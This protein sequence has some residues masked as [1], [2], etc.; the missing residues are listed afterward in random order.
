MVIGLT[1]TIGSGKTLVANILKEEFNVRIVDTDSISKEVTKKGTEALR[2]I[3]EIWGE[4]VISNDGELD[5]KR[6]GKII[7]NSKEDRDKLNKILHPLIFDRMLGIIRETDTK[8]DLIMV[9]PL[10]FETGIKSI[11]NKVW[12][13]I[14]SEE[15]IIGRLIKRESISYEEAKLRISSQM[16]Q[17]EK[18]KLADVII[19]N[20]FTPDETKKI[21]VREWKKWKGLK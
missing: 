13:V 18:M 4:E 7:F 2:K 20:S 21:V 6:L 9:V 17:E 8:D 12:L 14:C 11:F 19:D 5:R 1:G 3:K 15:I 10:L 16:P